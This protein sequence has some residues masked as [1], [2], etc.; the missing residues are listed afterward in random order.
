MTDP[1]LVEPAHAA[2]LDALE[3]RLVDT[4]APDDLL[5]EAV[6]DVFEADVARRPSEQPAPGNES[7]YE[8]AARQAALANNDGF[9]AQLEVLIIAYGPQATRTLVERILANRYSTAE[10]PAPSAPS[11]C[12]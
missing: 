10:T 8:S 2:A 4:G 3:Q 5:D 12:P 7:L 6:H 1:I 9:G 11:P